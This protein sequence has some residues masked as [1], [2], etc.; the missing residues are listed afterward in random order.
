MVCM[1][2]YEIGG[3]ARALDTRP[4]GRDPAPD[5]I[6]IDYDRVVWDP[7]YRRAVLDR[8]NRVKGPARER[9]KRRG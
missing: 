3:P 2:R 9:G 1:G 5:E 6:D 7:D 4:E 8:L